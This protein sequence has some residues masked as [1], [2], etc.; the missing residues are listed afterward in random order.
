MSS[1]MDGQVVRFETRR[2]FYRAPK[3]IPT[4]KRYAYSFI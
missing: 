2:Q 4:G 1:E 3:Q